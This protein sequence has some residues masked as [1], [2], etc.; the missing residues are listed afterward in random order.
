MHKNIP[1]EKCELC[2]KLI[3]IHDVALVCN[4][5]WK[6]YHAKC[7]KIDNDVASELQML[8][9]WYCP[10]CLEN[11]F[12]FFNS[13]SPETNR[14]INVDKCNTCNK[15]ISACR[16]EITRCIKCNNTC[17]PKC[18]NKLLC[19]ENKSFKENKSLFLISIYT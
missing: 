1:K 13:L 18:L 10:Y 5:D 6:I 11:S 12:P 16:Q 15:I 3:Y 14:R 8:P 17:H 9:D 19:K 4:L 2:H 7:L